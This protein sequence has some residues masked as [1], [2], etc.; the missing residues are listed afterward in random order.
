[1]TELLLSHER[2]LN[3]PRKTTTPIY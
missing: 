2:T 1:M 3:P